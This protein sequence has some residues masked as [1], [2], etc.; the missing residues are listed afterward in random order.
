[1]ELFIIIYKNCMKLLKNKK[2]DHVKN[3]RNFSTMKSFDLDINSF[4]IY[5][6]KFKNEI[7]QNLQAV[8]S[9]DNLN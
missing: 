8:K 5:F 3:N 2:F 7:R 9:I 6:I 4:R 1:M